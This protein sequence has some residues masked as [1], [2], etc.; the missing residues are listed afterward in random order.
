MPDPVF[1]RLM[2]VSGQKGLWGITPT[3]PGNVQIISR[4]SGD[5]LYS[6][7]CPT[8]PIALSLKSGNW[9]QLV[10]VADEPTT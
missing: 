10:I 5:V 8:S 3:A 4:P 1:Y 9:P 6:G 7:A 2:P